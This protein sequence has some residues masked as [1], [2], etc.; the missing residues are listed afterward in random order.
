MNNL[1]K[2]GV[3]FDEDRYLRLGHGKSDRILVVSHTDRNER[4]RLISARLATPRER[5]V[6]ENG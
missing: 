5:K 2:Y 6:Y 4:I 3:S 1:R